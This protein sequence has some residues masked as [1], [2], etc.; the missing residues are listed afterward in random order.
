MPVL[1]ST[2]NSEGSRPS[3]KSPALTRA[4]MDTSGIARRQ[5]RPPH[6]IHPGAIAPQS[7][8]HDG[9]PLDHP[10]QSRDMFIFRD[11]DLPFLNL[12]YGY[13]TPQAPEESSPH[14]HAPAPGGN[15]EFSAPRSHPP[16]WIDPIAATIRRLGISSGPIRP[17]VKRLCMTWE[18]LISNCNRLVE[19]RKAR[20]RQLLNSCPA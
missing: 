7:D 9:E 6:S 10:F 16:R 8:C 1:A 20:H 12:T 4:R 13:I 11:R 2:C 14:H 17:G 5:Y 19:S 3:A 15:P 18:A